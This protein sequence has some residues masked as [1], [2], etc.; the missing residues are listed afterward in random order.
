MMSSK[1]TISAHGL[2]QRE[3]AN[4]LLQDRVLD[5]NRAV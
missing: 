4:A 3:C 1:R 5:K 2:V